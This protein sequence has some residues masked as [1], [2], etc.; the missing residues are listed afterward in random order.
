MSPI[1]SH[2]DTRYP[3]LRMSDASNLEESHSVYV[4]D[5]IDLF[6]Q[7]KTYQD[8]RPYRRQYSY[9]HIKRPRRLSGLYHERPF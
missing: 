2:E 4:T 3:L 8:N 7:K 6:H 5:F 9:Q 1:I